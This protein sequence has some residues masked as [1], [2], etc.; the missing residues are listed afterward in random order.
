M[1][2]ASLLNQSFTHKRQTRTATGSGTFPLSESTVGT[3][4]GRS[5]TASPSEA[6]IALANMGTVTHVVYTGASHTFN[7]DDILERGAQSL[8]IRGV[9]TPSNENHHL[10]VFAQEEVAGK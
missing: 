2:P 10:K 1:I 5:R 7:L 6:S 4:R 9:E 8:R 3:V